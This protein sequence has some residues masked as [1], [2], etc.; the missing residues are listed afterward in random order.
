MMGQSELNNLLYMLVLGIGFEIRID[1][2]LVLAIRLS[3]LNRFCELL[4]FTRVYNTIARLY[5]VHI[6]MLYIVGKVSF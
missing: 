5:P 3:I 4:S 1:Y 2:R 6:G